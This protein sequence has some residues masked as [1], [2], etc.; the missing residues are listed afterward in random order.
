MY[1]ASAEAG[2]RGRHGRALKVVRGLQDDASALTRCSSEVDDEPSFSELIEGDWAS[3]V[4]RAEWPPLLSSACVCPK[5]CVRISVAK[6]CAASQR[7]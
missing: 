7:R 1:R 6:P 3:I 4:D 5:A 2:D